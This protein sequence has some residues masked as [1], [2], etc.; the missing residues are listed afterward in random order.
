MSDCTAN[1]PQG[2]W[3]GIDVSGRHVDVCVIDSHEQVRWRR[4]YER[5]AEALQ[6]LVQQLAP[7]SPQRIVLEA[8]GG[9]E[10]VVL[11]VL[12]A[13][14]L[15]VVCVNPQRVRAFARADGRLAKTD[16][17][18]AELLALFAARMRPPLRPLPS[19]EQ[20]RLADLA[21]RQQQLIWMR[22]AERHRLR[23]CT[24]AEVRH[25]LEQ[26]IDFLNR[27]LQAIEQAL[28]ERIAESPSA[29]RRAELLRSTPSVGQKTAHRLVAQLPEL[30]Q[31]N[32]RQI[33]ALV[34]LAPMAA[35]SGEQRGKRFLQGGRRSVRCTL[36][37]AA[38]AGLRHNW[39]IRDF[40][41]R[42]CA[43]GKP[44]K[45]A[46]LAAARKLLVILNTML[47]R[48]SFWGPEVFQPE[49][50]SSGLGPRPAVSRRRAPPSPATP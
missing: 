28:A 48:D 35:D 42:L 30:G 45:L 6:S 4:R 44:P 26:T 1:S 2:C 36:Y 15:P 12:S 21:A 50:P 41:M 46:L 43:H 11:A 31:L 49:R 8:T 20:R 5:H 22:T 19:Q 24:Q 38:L 23:R 47:Q 7:E 25:S 17:L 39:V 16:P 13:A 37:M 9:L 34:G 18:D 29:T 3:V 40:Y 10:R 14:G 27:Q 33:A 32:R